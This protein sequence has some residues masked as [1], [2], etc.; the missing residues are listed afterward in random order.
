MSFETSGMCVITHTNTHTHTYI[1][2]N[3]QA[4]IRSPV[5]VIKY[6]IS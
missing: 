5:I 3:T 2:T 6:A 4:G 1:Y